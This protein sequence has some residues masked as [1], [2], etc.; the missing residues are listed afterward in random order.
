MGTHASDPS[1]RGLDAITQ[2]SAADCTV[3]EL[4]RGPSIQFS[5]KV[6][7]DLCKPWHNTIV[8]KPLGRTM[9]YNFLH[10]RLTSRW[11]LEGPWFLIDIPNDF[12]L[13]KFVMKEDMES[14]LTGGPLMIAGQYVAMQRWKSDFDAANHRVTHLAV[15]VRIV[16]LD[17][18]YFK[19]DSLT[20]I[21]SLLGETVKVDLHTAAQARGKYARIC[22]ELDLNKPLRAEL[23]VKST[24][25]RIEYECMPT[26]CYSCGIVGHTKVNCPGSKEKDSVVVVSSKIAVDGMVATMETDATHDHGSNSQMVHSSESTKNQGKDVDGTMVVGLGPWNDVSNKKKKSD[27]KSE[28]SGSGKV[29]NQ[30]SRFQVLANDNEDSSTP[31]ELEAT[32]SIPANSKTWRPVQEKS[33]LKKNYAKNEQK[34]Q[35]ILNMKLSDMKLSSNSKGKNKSKTITAEQSA[36]E[37]SATRDEQ[38]TQADEPSQ[39]KGKTVKKA[40]RQ[41]KV[42][43]DVKNGVSIRPFVIQS[44]TPPQPLSVIPNPSTSTTTSPPKAPDPSEVMSTQKGNGV[45]NEM[46][47]TMMLMLASSA[48]VSKDIIPADVSLNADMADVVSSVDDTTTPHC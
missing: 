29:D 12:F 45:N 13:V 22:V 31:A 6:E 46:V 24:W 16:G 5:E 25:Y 21:G 17:I 27:M 42:L 2:I 37:I 4:E 32:T 8:L 9:S 23:Q 3:C 38:A 30:G 44:Q 43:K 36:H 14:V 34:S 47:G 33:S 40:A 15:W 10:Q 1:T 11:N 18:R 28:Y 35:S 26:F 19:L 7:E 20:Q 48:E 39:T 41:R